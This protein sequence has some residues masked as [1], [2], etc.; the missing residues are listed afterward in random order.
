MAIEPE[1]A[2]VAREMCAAPMPPN[3]E[4]LVS[5]SG[6]VYFHDLENDYYTVE[7]PLTQRYLKVMERERLYML[8][9]RT[10]PSVNA[11]QFHQPAEL[12]NQQFPNLQERT[13]IRARSHELGM[14]MES[15]LHR[16]CIVNA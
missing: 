6:I 14:A 9:L 13:R 7:H 5:K 11:L 12:F 1:L 16:Q 8:A 3:A 15:E 4:M 10:K 2:W